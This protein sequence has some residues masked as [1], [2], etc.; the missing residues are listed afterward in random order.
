M[1]IRATAPFYDKAEGIDRDEGEEWEVDEE[2]LAA[3]NSTE[4]GILADA[5]DP[6]AKAP[7]K[8]PAK[9]AARKTAGKG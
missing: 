8:A 1:R 2:R 4:Y 6:P 7:T 3:I 9:R 5:V